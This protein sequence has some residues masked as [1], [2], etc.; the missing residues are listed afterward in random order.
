[1]SDDS[2]IIS[3]STPSLRSN[4]PFEAA[5]QETFAG[6]PSQV[7]SRTSRA[8]AALKSG[9]PRATGSWGV[10]FIGGVLTG[11]GAVLTA[12]GIGAAAG[13]PLMIAGGVIY[14]ISQGVSG[15]QARRDA[16]KAGESVAQALGKD[17]GKASLHSAAAASWAPPGPVVAHSSA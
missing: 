13:V 11:V 10:K 14:G 17:F 15:I 2:S 5:F 6:P 3:V 16:R 9:I 4:D 7:S 8:L 12:T 1:V